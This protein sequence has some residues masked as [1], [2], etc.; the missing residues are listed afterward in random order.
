MG[1]AV[2]VSSTV[3]T[4]GVVPVKGALSHRAATAPRRSALRV[5][6]EASPRE[7]SAVP[8]VVASGSGSYTQSCAH[9]GVPVSTGV[10]ASSRWNTAVQ[11]LLTIVLTACAT[12]VLL[13]VAH[14]RTVSVVAD[15]APGGVTVVHTGI[16]V[17]GSVV[18]R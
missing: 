1:T 18:G 10:S 13:G 11:V 7:R 14:L 12:V 17:A 5:S 16:D 3:S 9:R 8:R 4:S 6:R 15:T 2:T